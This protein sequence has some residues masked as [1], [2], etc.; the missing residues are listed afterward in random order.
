MR[1][2]NNLLVT[3]G[4]GF[5]GSA[6]IRYILNQTAFTGKLINYD[7]LTYSGNLENLLEIEN[8]PRYLFQQGDLCNK[9]LIEEICF[10]H[11]INCIV[12]FAAETHVDRSIKEPLNFIQTNLL[13]TVSLLEVLR[14]YPHIHLH[15]ISTD[16]VYGSLKDF[17]SFTEDSPYKPSSPYSASKAASDH[18]LNAYATT[19]RL[20]T[21]LSNCSNNY[22]PCQYPEK[23]IPLII[24]N[25]MEG[26]K[27]P[28][29]GEG[30]NIRDW[31]YVED[32]VEAIW[33]ILQHARPGAAYNIGGQAEKTNLDLVKILISIIAKF[34]NESPSTYLNLVEF[35]QDRPGHDYRYAIDF[36]KIRKELNWHPKHTLEAGLIKTVEWY[37]THPSW[38]KNL[39]GQS[40]HQWMET[41]YAK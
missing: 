2:L 37:L 31:L 8:D 14:K 7:L 40:Y 28:I 20:S 33:M 13:G 32:H 3:G 5:I 11:D 18:F 1:K 26:K 16:E 41:H 12:N 15:H 17:G 36:S 10:E 4:A 39:Q 29:Y 21:T 34:Q 23:L 27:L 38:I 6:F 22:G 25:C 9:N 30:A 24:L 19:Y 35:V